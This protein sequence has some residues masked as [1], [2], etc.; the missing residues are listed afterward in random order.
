MSFLFSGKADHRERALTFFFEL[1]YLDS[2]IR[3]DD[4]MEW[5]SWGDGL[6]FTIVTCDEST[7]WL[8]SNWLI[9]V[10]MIIRRLTRDIE[11]MI[12]TS[13]CEVIVRNLWLQPAIELIVHNCCDLSVLHDSVCI[14]KSHMC[15]ARILSHWKCVHSLQSWNTM[16]YEAFI[17]K[18]KPKQTPEPRRLP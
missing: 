1:A 12:W 10:T 7:L 6:S 4:L 15:N 18:Q 17:P 2:L 5:N 9:N 16:L 3:V 8:W 14:V 11:I 13:F